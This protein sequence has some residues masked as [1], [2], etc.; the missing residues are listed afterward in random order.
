[1]EALGHVDIDKL[2]SADDSGNDSSSDG[3]NGAN[4]CKKGRRAIESPTL[5]ERSDEDEDM[6]LRRRNYIEEDEFVSKKVINGLR[7]Y[8]EF[9]IGDTEESFDEQKEALQSRLT[10]D[11][12]RFCVVR[13]FRPDLIIEQ[14]KRLIGAFLDESFTNIGPFNYNDVMRGTDHYA[15]NLLILGPDVDAHQELLRMR[16]VLK[17]ETL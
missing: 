13:V 1:M 16:K 9:R 17:K 14:V 8:S 11:M 10:R 12:L 5:E 15:A 3:C 2:F 6:F 4:N 7:E